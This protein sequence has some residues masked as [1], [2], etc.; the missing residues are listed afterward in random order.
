[1]VSERVYFPV[2]PSLFIFVMQVVSRKIFSNI[3][4]EQVELS[5]I[6]HYLNSI[7]KLCHV[8][9]SYA[10]R[11][12]QLHRSIPRY[13]LNFFSKLHYIYDFNTHDIQND[14]YTSMKIKTSSTISCI[15]IEFTF[16]F[17]GRKFFKQ[18]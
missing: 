18:G 2:Y 1:M 14:I 9:V 10:S 5:K 3:F 8:N 16:N 15:H 11:P 13:H 7:C 4:V 12:P 6:C 17:R